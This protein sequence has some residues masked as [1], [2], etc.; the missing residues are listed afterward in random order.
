MKQQKIQSFD[1]TPIHCYI[2]DEV[3]SPKGIVQIVHGMAEHAGRYAPFAEFLNS[4]GYIV[5]GDDHRAHGNT[6]P[7]ETVGYHKGDIYKDT[8]NDLIYLY[9][10]FKNEYKLPAMVLGHSYGSFLS[11]GF[12]QQGT[13]VKGVILCGSAMMGTLTGTFGSLAVAPLNFFASSYRPKFV[14]K[15]SDLMFNGVYTGEKGRL[16]WVTRDTAEREKMIADPIAGIDMSINFD[17]CMIKAFSR[18]YRKENLAKLNL[19]TPIGIFS[20]TMDPIGGKN[21]K[22]AVKLYEMYKKCGV[23]RCEIHL[24]DEARHELLNEINRDEVYSDMLAFIDK[25]FA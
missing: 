8:L 6:E 5:F 19:D 18:L 21:A 24:Y 13:D 4:K 12:L 22:K 16:L 2:W 11:Q 1:S 14:N 17:Y 25:C 3:D 10:Y 15:I 7:I 20:G 23:N 9:N